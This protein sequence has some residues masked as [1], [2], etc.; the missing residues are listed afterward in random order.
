MGSRSLMHAIQLQGETCY[1]LP[2]KALFRPEHDT[3]Y[4]A[5]THFGKATT[6]RR[7]ALYV[8]EGSTADD[9]TRLSQALIS[10]QARRLVI[11]GDL[12]HA[13]EGRDPKMLAGVTRWR[14]QHP[15]L[16]IVLV[17]GNHDR[18]AGDPPSDWRITSVAAPYPDAP[19]ILQHQPQPHPSGYVLAG[20]L[21]PAVELAGKGKQVLRLPCF[22][23]RPQVMILPAF[24]SFTGRQPIKPTASD[25]I[26]V[27]AEQKVIPIAR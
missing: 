4:I 22:W 6:F 27:I 1:L 12:L 10:T 24:T 18:G 9:L 13:P 21:H 26:F 16:E 3:L 17:R 15:D 23:I 25:Q 19:F 5:D 8:P 11:L 14:D 7:H 2:E 20:H